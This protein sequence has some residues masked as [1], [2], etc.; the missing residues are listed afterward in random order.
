MITTKVSNGELVTSDA[1][2]QDLQPDTDSQELIVTP[3]VVSGTLKFGTGPA[4]GSPVI[5]G[6]QGTWGSYTTANPRALRTIQPGK[7][8]FR[9]VGAGSF[10]FSW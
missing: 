9:V 6:N 8:N 4:G 7:I 3:E 1:T 10:I 2:E 5:D